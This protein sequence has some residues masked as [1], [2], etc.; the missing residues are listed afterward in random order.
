MHPHGPPVSHLSPS[1]GPMCQGNFPQSSPPRSMPA[2][3]LLT[4]QLLLCAI[5]AQTTIA[6]RSHRPT[7]SPLP[8]RALPCTPFE[9]IV[10][11]P[12]RGHAYCLPRVL[13]QIPPT[14]R[15]AKPLSG[16]R[17]LSDKQHQ[18]TSPPKVI[19]VGRSCNRA[20]CSLPLLPAQLKLRVCPPASHLRSNNRV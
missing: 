17:P 2:A 3:A 18:A 4:A 9:V 16:G 15:R 10:L 11:L 14:P 1:C 13:P 20:T 7:Q 8:A 5:H 19:H 12:V 6:S